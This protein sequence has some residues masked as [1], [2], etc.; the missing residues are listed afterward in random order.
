MKKKFIVTGGTGFIGAALVKAL[1]KEGHSVCSFDNNS[2]GAVS[3]LGEVAKDV[4]LI[5][6]DIRNRDLVIRAAKGR[7]VFVHLAYVNGTEFFYTKPDLVLDV[8]IRGMMNV[9][10]ACE[11][12]RIENFIL[13]S[14]SEVYQ[15]PPEIPTS[16]NV[17]LIVPNVL[18][19]RYSYGGGKIA[20][21]LLTLHYG[22]RFFKRASIFRPH[23]VYGPDMG[24][25]HVVP[26][27]SLRLKKLLQTHRSQKLPFEIQ[28]DGMQTRSF[29]YIDDFT[30]GL[31]R[32]I[33]QGAHN[34]IYHIGTQDEV[35][36][37]ELASRMARLLGHELEFKTLEEPMGATRR[38]LPDTTKL[39]ALGFK[40]K[41][42]LDAG[43]K[44]TMD[45]Y[46]KD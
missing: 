29:I 8:A 7:E 28:G 13:A 22:K 38:R 17:P 33:D 11:E 20:C 9:L 15:S 43:L 46:L 39:K 36:M 41:V 45:W 3:K 25:E 6:G 19:P 4:E 10:D 23:N 16:E 12:N 21:E 35:S 31:M 26:Q 14:S 40:P 32:V 42:S 24:V 5:E 18:N 27:F 44:T 2:R 30:D 34:E 1:V 37:R